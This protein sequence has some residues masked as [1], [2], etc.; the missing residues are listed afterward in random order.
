MYTYVYTYMLIM[1]LF[2][3]YVIESYLFTYIQQF[4]TYIMF[5]IG[6]IH[7]Q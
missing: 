7:V 2:N 5:E 3:G 1:H 4:K 6:L